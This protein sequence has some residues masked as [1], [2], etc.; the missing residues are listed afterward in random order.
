MPTRPDDG[1]FCLEAPPNELWSRGRMASEFNV[2]EST[3]DGWV[4]NGRLPQP[5]TRRRGRPLWAPET[6]EPAL[7]RHRQCPNWGG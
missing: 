5:W 6:V 1:P 4:R 7:R 2:R 3:I